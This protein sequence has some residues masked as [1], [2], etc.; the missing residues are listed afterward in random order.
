VVRININTNDKSEAFK[1][2][3]NYL[4]SQGFK[5]VDSDIKRPWGFYFYVNEKQTDK[6]IAFFYSGVSLDSIDTSLPLQPKILV[7]EPG[8]KNSWQYHHRRAEIWRCLSKDCQVLM[9]QDDKEPK[10]TIIKNSEVVNF[11]QGTRHRGG[12]IDN[13]AVVA[14]IWQH[15]D[16][17]NPSDEA[18]IIRLQDDFG[19][20]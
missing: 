8:K 16:P 1:E 13:W 12:G 4:T 17:K 9:S 15:T 2:V 6:F 5:I 20:K 7:F 10:P 14:E 18:D 11:A 3:E 19:R